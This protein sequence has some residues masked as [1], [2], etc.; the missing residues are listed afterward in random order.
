MSSLRQFLALTFKKM[1][2]YTYI[3]LDGLHLM[4][5]KPINLKRYVESRR[6]L[7]LP[8]GPLKEVK[9]GLL[10]DKFLQHL[11]ES[12]KVSFM[13]L[14]KIFFVNFVETKLK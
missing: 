14:N 12:L 11:Y 2:S 8:K 3:R 7:T 4:Q 9:Q 6:D 5:T 1:F 13:F 10:N